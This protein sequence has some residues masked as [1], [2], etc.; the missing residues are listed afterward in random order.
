MSFYSSS[1]KCSQIDPRLDQSNQRAEFRFSSDT[2]YLSN[3]RLLNVGITATQGDYNKGAGVLSVIKNI[4]LLDGAGQ[5]L[6]QLRNVNRYGAFL[7]YNSPNDSNKSIN[8]FLLQH[9][10]GYEV[11]NIDDTTV[12]ESI[13]VRTPFA[14]PKFDTTLATTNRGWIDLKKLLPMLNSVLYL[15]TQVFKNLTLRIEF[16]SAVGTAQNT[17]APL[18]V[19]DSMAEGENAMRMVKAFKGAD[20][21]SVEHDQVFIDALSP[22]A[23]TP[24]PTQSVRKMMKGFDNKFLNRVVLIKE[25]SA[26]SLGRSTNLGNLGS[27]LYLRE[28]ENLR[29]NGRSLLVGDGLDTPAKALA[30]VSDV[31]GTCNAYLNK[32]STNQTILGTAEL[33]ILGEQDNRAFLVSEYVE[34]LEVSFSRTGD[35]DTGETDANNKLN[36]INN[37]LTLHA[38]GDVKKTL[39]V[40]PDGSY[41]I[42]YPRA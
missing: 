5:V 13:V 34:D 16:N 10:M 32:L 22:V 39:Q 14:N 41:L 1:I 20:Y 35:R 29:V 40:Q 18:L 7:N 3:M 25:P 17:T 28:K 2:V 31:Y 27:Q 9:G 4:Q 19:V 33:D 36:K 12:P 38:F 24:N 37:S 42:S 30:K 6:D 23:A 8:H 11:G 26:D 21:V 15:P